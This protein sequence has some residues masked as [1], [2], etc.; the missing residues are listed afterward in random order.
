MQRRDALK[1]LLALCSVAASVATA[2]AGLLSLLQSLMGF[3]PPRPAPTP[4]PERKRRIRY[5]GEGDDGGSGEW[6]SQ[7]QEIREE[8]ITDDNGRKIGTNYVFVFR[9]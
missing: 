9:D 2:I 5:D 3:T 4:K 7:L 1:G 8:A 6:E